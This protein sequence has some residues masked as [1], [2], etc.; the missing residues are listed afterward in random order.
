MTKKRQRMPDLSKKEDR[1][2]FIKM[3]GIGLGFVSKMI[4]ESYGFRCDYKINGEMI[5]DIQ[6]L[7]EL[8]ISERIQLSIREE[9]YEDAAV[10]KK[11]LDAKKDNHQ[12]ILNP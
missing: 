9:R 10:L 6:K 5:Q 1:D 8:D 2:L 11:I 3:I 7:R 4:L 12:N